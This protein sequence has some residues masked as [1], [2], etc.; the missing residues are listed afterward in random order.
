MLRIT[1]LKTSRRCAEN[2]ISF[3]IVV[4]R[5]CRGAQENHGWMFAFVPGAPLN[6]NDWLVIRKH[7]AVQDHALSNVVISTSRTLPATLSSFR[8]RLH[9]FLSV[10]FDSR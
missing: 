10:L 7:C 4:G 3:I 2:A 8:H 9:S 1:S 6:F 5:I